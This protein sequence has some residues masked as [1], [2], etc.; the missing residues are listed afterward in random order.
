MEIVTELLLDEVDALDAAARTLVLGGEAALADELGRSGDV[1]WC[2]IDIRERTAAGRTNVVVV[3]DIDSSAYDRIV[4]PVPPN[5]DLARRWL[6]TARMALRSEGV[7]VL[8]GANAEGAKSVVADARSV[9]SE[10]MGEHYARKHRIARFHRS[11]APPDLPGWAK[12]DGLLPGTW[13][14]FAVEI[15]G[16]EV[17]LE[18]QPGVFAGNRLDAGTQL[19]LANLVIREGERALDVGC[20]AGVIGIAASLRGAGATD[21]VDA[22]LLAVE[23]SARNLAR[24]GIAGRALASDVFSAVADERYD[25]IVSNPPF[26]RGKAVDYAVA[27]RLIS[28]APGHLLDG[29]RLLIVANAF[30]A[31]GKRMERFFHSVELV[32]ATRQYHIL[33]AREPR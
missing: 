33:Q 21:L 12:K 14:R 18:T 28:E 5:R 15:D 19:L 22:N 4:V 29:G 31:Y 27:D 7:L 30:L 25:L 13:Q 3:D 11:E 26:H 1:A 2:P 24:L 23:A 8:A 6:L 32:A 10:P 20:G 9:F 17:V 16:N